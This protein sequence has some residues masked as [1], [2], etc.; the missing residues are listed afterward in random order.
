MAQ[1]TSVLGSPGGFAGVQAQ[2]AVA[3]VDARAGVTFLFPC[4]AWL[5][6]RLGDGKTERRLQ[7]AT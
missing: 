5:D 3:G 7:A 6:E 1:R 4:D 2:A